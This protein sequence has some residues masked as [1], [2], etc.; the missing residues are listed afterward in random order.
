MLSESTLL[1]LAGGAFGVASRC[2]CCNEPSLG[3]RRSGDDRVP[4]LVAL[5]A[6]GILV[7]AVVGILAGIFPG[8][9][10]ARTN[11]VASLRT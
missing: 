8:L 10:A 2:S 7:A 6:T 1:S 9:H 11:I 3:R 5:A 4:A